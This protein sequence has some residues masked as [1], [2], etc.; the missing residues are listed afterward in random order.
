MITGESILKRDLI[1]DGEKGCLKN[2]TYDLTILKFFSAGESAKTP[3]TEGTYYLKPRGMVWVI[4]KEEFKLPD[5]VTGIATLRTTLPPIY[6]LHY[7]KSRKFDINKLCKCLLN[8][9][10]GQYKATILLRFM[11]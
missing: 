8:R 1:K 2:S 5:T 11:L 6:T 4:S 7:I 10:S 3:I 9:L